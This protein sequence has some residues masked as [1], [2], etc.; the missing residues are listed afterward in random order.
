MPLIWVYILTCGI[1]NFSTSMGQIKISLKLSN[2][3]TPLF[4]E[5]LVTV[6][7]RKP[8]PCETKSLIF[9]TI[10]YFY[11][12]QIPLCP[13]DKRVEGLIG[14]VYSC[15]RLVLKYLFCEHANHLSTL[16]IINFL[17]GN[18]VPFEMVVQLFRAWNENTTGELVEHFIYYYGVYQN[19]RD[20]AHL[21][22]YFDL[23]IEKHLY[24]NG[25]R[26]HQHEIVDFF[27]TSEPKDI[28]FGNLYTDSIR[29]NPTI[30]AEQ[31]NR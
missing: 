26:R 31:N 11:S 12:L 30:S 2:L 17:Y 28:G 8:L 29:K 4:L 9:H 5:A 1:R 14:T 6:V 10:K 15:P 7:T 19:S 22:I 13:S 25:S 16:T 24:I 20:D 27:D 3:K 23:K 18:G 21:G